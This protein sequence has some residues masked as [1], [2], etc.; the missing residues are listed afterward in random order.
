MITICPSTILPGSPLPPYPQVEVMS[1]TELKVTWEEPFT[2]ESFPILDYSITVYN[3][4]EPNES[5]TYTVIDRSKLITIDSETT[6]CSLLIFNVT[7]R[8]EIERSRIET[9]SGGFPV[10]EFM[11]LVQIIC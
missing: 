10:G 7:A 5:Y 1:T 6:T 4:S 8:N 9:T 2:F 11:Q 3:S